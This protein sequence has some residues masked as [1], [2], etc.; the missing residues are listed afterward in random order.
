[1]TDQDRPVEADNLLAQAQRNAY[2][3]EVR[4][5]FTEA[6]GTPEA[7]TPQGNVMLH[8]LETFAGRGLPKCET[9]DA[10]ATDIARTFRKLGQR[11]MLEII[12]DAISWRETHEP[13]R[14]GRP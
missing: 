1:M 6:F 3:R 8:Y 11:D 13:N 2:R 12:N 14:L 7:R 10:G 5:A 9:T 4:Q